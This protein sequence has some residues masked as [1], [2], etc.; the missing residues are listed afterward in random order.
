MPDRFDNISLDDLL[1]RAAEARAEG[2]ALVRAIKRRLMAECPVKIGKI[3]RYVPDALP[4]FRGK[5]FLVCALRVDNFASF[6]TV[7]RYAVGVHGFNALKNSSAGDGFG[8]KPH[9]LQ[10]WHLLD[11]DSERD[12]PR[13]QLV[14]YAR[15]WEE[16]E[17]AG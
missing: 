12:G 11:I 13:P 8:I 2:D 3:Y 9:V 5:D 4:W 17:N 7:P 10:D 16:L 14:E 15:R 1:A 6:N